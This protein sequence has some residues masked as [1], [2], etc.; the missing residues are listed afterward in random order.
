M[1]SKVKAMTD[2]LAVMELSREEQVSLVRHLQEMW[3]IPGEDLLPPSELFNGV[4]RIEGLCREVRD[5]LKPKETLVSVAAETLMPGNDETAESSVENAGSADGDGEVSEDNAGGDNDDGDGKVSEDNA[6]GEVPKEAEGRKKR[7]AAS[8][9]PKPPRFSKNGK[10]LGRPPKN[11]QPQ[12][13]VNPAD[14]TVDTE[15]EEVV[16]AAA[17]ISASDDATKAPAIAA[18]PSDNGVPA[19]PVFDNTIRLVNAEDVEGAEALKMGKRYDFAIIYKWAARLYVKSHYVLSGMYPEGVC[20]NYEGIFKSDYTQFAISLADEVPGVMLQQARAYA[21]NKLPRFEGERWKV[22]DS[23]QQS[24]TRKVSEDLNRLLNKL[25][26]DPFR[27]KYVAGDR[28]D[29]VMPGVKIR[30][31]IDIK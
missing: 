29:V 6:G 7:K 14:G 11:V 18:V 20:I 4:M 27:G 5:L 19:A 24:M 30:Y 13:V 25:S 21:A 3:N 9:V 22:M 10:R 17:E 23:V 28:S 26:G 8:A 15:T 1:N 31:A 16:E 2:M 12:T